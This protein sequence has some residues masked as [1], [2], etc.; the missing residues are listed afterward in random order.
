MSDSCKAGL[1]ARIKYWVRWI[2]VLPS[3]A[4]GYILMYAML[5]V[6][7]PWPIS[8]IYPDDSLWL[9]LMWWGSAPVGFLCVGSQMAPEKKL[10]F[11]VCLVLTVVFSVTVG[12]FLSKVITHITLMD[13][14]EHWFA[15]LAASVQLLSAIFWTLQAS[16]EEKTPDTV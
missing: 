4:F 8:E 2:L 3:A 1:T 5:E 7:R 9:S 10:R 6:W 13:F 12:I 14:Q 15:L 11:H 16:R